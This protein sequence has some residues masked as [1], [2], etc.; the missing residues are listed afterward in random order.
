MGYTA[1]LAGRLKDLDERRFDSCIG[2]SRD[3]DSFQ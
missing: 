2:H 1:A 3:L